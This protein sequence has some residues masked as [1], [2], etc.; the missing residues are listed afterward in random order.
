M[1]DERRESRD[2]ALNELV[3]KVR[4]GITRREERRNTPFKPE[5][6]TL[7]G[8]RRSIC[9]LSVLTSYTAMMSSSG[10]LHALT[11]LLG[12]PLASISSDATRFC[13]HWYLSSSCR[14][15]CRLGLVQ[16]LSARN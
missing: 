11:E 3:P 4:G 1:E 10:F 5:L 16:F 15:R 9:Q 7:F 2:A 12:F 13:L 6:C 14:E 8:I